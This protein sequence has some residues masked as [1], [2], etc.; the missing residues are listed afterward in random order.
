[1]WRRPGA[2]CAGLSTAR[3][4]AVTAVT[5]VCL[6]VGGVVFVGGVAGWLELHGGVLDVDVSGQALQLIEQAGQMTVVEA[7]VVDHDVGGEHRQ[8]LRCRAA[9]LA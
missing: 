2:G 1:M 9:N 8:A 4:S 3:R 5:A 6:F 7:F